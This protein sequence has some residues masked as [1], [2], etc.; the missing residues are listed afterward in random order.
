M[1]HISDPKRICFA[2]PSRGGATFPA[3]SLRSP[4]LYSIACDCLAGSCAVLRCP[5]TTAVNGQR[6]SS[7]CFVYNSQYHG[8]VQGDALA[9]ATGGPARARS[10]PPPPPAFSIPPLWALSTKEIRV[11]PA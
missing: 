3:R 2:H 8:L 1:M 11:A 7:S 9:P 5:L 6:H 10:L 4:A